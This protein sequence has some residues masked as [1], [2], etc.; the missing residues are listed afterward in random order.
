MATKQLEILTKFKPEWLDSISKMNKFDEFVS[1]IFV[2]LNIN[3]NGENYLVVDYDHKLDEDDWLSE[4][5]PTLLIVASRCIKTEL[6]L[7]AVRISNL[8]IAA[9]NGLNKFIFNGEHIDGVNI[10]S[11]KDYFSQPYSLETR[12]VYYDTMVEKGVR[13]NHPE[14]DII[15]NNYCFCIG[16]GRKRVRVSEYRIPLGQVDITEVDNGVIKSFI[17]KGAY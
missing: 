4:L 17:H 5:I 12:N 8:L 7:D 13:V 9:K 6:K 11:V 16:D 1:S 3:P 14:F 15:V 10:K 2:N